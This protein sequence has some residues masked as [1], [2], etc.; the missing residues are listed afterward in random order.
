MKLC[1]SLLEIKLDSIALLELRQVKGDCFVKCWCTI[2]SSRLHPSTTKFH[3]RTN[4]AALHRQG[5]EPLT[6]DC[7][8]SHHPDSQRKA[9]QPGKDKVSRLNFLVT[10]IFKLS[11][12]LYVN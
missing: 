2:L 12:S 4:S 9:G 5:Q 10:S 1:F 7:P 8:C 3:R 6:A 11:H